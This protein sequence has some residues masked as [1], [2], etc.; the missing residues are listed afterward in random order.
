MP[1]H[2]LLPEALQL[3]QHVLFFV[4]LDVQLALQLFHFPSERERLKRRGGRVVSGWVDDE[5]MGGERVG[6]E[7]MRGSGSVFFLKL[8]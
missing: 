3:S 6:D 1:H 5:R 2:H 7:R 8:L 4:P